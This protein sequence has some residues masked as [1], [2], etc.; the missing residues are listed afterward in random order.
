MKRKKRSL[1]SR[2]EHW[3]LP[4]PI[5]WIVGSLSHNLGYK[6]LSLV[7]AIL[8]WSYV[9]STNTSITRTKTLY[10]LT[11]DIS[12]LSALAEHKLALKDDP[13]GMLDGISVIVEAPQADY[14]KVS[15]SNVLVTLDLSNVR[16]QGKQEV[17]LRASSTYGR[18]RSIS[19]ETLTLEFETLDSRNVSVNPVIT[20]Q[21]EGYW[22]NITR[23]NP[24]MLTV[25]GAA[26][27]VQSIASAR[28]NVDASGITASTTTALPYEFIDAQGE[29]VPQAMLNCST[30]SISV[31]M[32]VYPTREIP[33][34]REVANLVTGQPAEGYVLQS[35]TVSPTTIQVAAEQELLDS[36]TELMIEPV[37]VEGATQNFSAKSTVS[38]LTDF[39]NVSTS[40]VYVN[41]A[42]GEEPVSAY[43]ENVK[44]MF[45]GKA[46]NIVATYDPVGVFVS[47]ARGDVESLQE[48]GVT[49]N[50]DITD[51]E[52]GYYL[53]DPTYD[54]QMYSNV[55][56]QCEA[57][58]VT[59]TDIS[60]D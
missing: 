35:V 52:A 46:D 24:L 21:A 55:T 4:G 18:V 16:S 3:K 56:L 28:V 1:K 17:A 47:G 43:V 36:L 34:T 14:S 42:V 53:L 9:I 20:G 31:T 50:V 25:S 5:R 57:V 40:E 32:D 30:S 45:I 12:G 11:G 59:L 38:Q 44:V 60:Q 48:S 41:V 51:L 27:I 19:P 49:L 23:S 6:L 22:Y 29:M 54:E 7:L 15:S 13:E 33:V 8:L 39:K 10:N 26:S 37:S 58:S 2:V